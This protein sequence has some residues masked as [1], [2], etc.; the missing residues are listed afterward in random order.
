[1]I[2]LLVAGLAPFHSI[3]SLRFLVW[4]LFFRKEIEGEGA[5]HENDIK[6]MSGET[7]EET[8]GWMRRRNRKRRR[9]ST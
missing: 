3:L 1:M 8:K 7:E 2:K 6:R 5:R 9:I 4:S